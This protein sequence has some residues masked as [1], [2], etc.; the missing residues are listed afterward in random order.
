LTVTNGTPSTV[1]QGSVITYVESTTGCNAT[2][3]N[4]TA[5]TTRKSITIPSIPSITVSTSGT[6]NVVTNISAS[7]HT[8]TQSLGSVTDEKVRLVS[9][10]TATRAFVMQ[11]DSQ[12]GYLTS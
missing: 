7:G 10:G 11:G 1:A 9:P 5:T 2:S 12:T 8:I 6:G 3:G 4:L